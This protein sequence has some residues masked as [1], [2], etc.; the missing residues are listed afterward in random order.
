M[1]RP[2]CVISESL[3]IAGNPKSQKIYGNGGLIRSLGTKRFCSTSA[4]SVSTCGSLTQLTSFNKKNKRFINDKLI[5]IIAN[6]KVL[7]LAYET[8]QRKIKNEHFSV[9]TRSFDSIDLN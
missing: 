7:A 8:V 5:N 6:P 9:C 2:K 1:Q 3:V 4:F